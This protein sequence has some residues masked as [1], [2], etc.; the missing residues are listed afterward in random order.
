MDLS[1]SRRGRR[2]LFALLYLAEGA[3]IGFIWWAVPTRLREAGVP[4]GT[5]ALLT[6]VIILPWAFK[7]LWAPLVDV[8]RGPRW[9]RRGWI[10]SAQLVMG[11]TLLPLAFT[12]WQNSLA[13]L[14]GL[15]I[16][17]A[18]AAAT[19]DVAIDAWAIS[20]TP[21]D[22]RG[23]LNGAMQSGM[24]VGRWLFGAGFL[25]V[26]H[27]I[28]DAL[29]V[30]AMVAVIWVTTLSVL[31]ASD[32]D[33]Y[34]IGDAGVRQ[35]IQA[36]LATLF[37]VL[38]TPVTYLGIAV[39]LI[40]FA[41]FK[42]VG[43]IAGPFLVDLGLSQGQVGH[44]FTGALV[45]MILGALAGGWLADRFGHARA[46]SAFVVVAAAVIFATSA[47]AW[48]TT[49]AH[50]G[51]V[52]GMLAVYLC[53]GLLTASAYA[54]FMQI[55]DPRLGATQFSAYMGA[56]NGCEAWAGFTAGQLAERFDYPI[57]FVTVA[58]ASLLALP[59][60]ALLLRARRLARVDGIAPKG[61]GSGGAG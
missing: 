52:A 32:V 13:L 24:L 29:V 11:L 34:H 49:G 53:A 46:V 1:R 40:A 42:A 54:L 37:S 6:S 39:A 19:Q 17:H 33:D 9:G 47:V 3:P 8:L 36:F 51:V 22:E 59:L 27:R 2:A 44:F 28:D 30:F 25:I 7:F 43:D 12:D 61:I 23:M 26:A 60:I 41:G 50:V 57:A 10:V 35:R 31:L 48:L 15:L 45:A 21:V 55:T 18:F 58:L 38:R 14:F 4:V 5:I 20:V 56:I 16:L